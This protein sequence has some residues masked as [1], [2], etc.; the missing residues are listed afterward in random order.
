MPQTR[1][2]R[3]PLIA[4]LG[5]VLWD[6]FPDGEAFGGAPANFAC[7]CQA[8]GADAV[9]VSAVGGDERGR[10]A[11]AFLDEH[12]VDTSYVQVL[13]DAPTGAVVVRLD[14]AGKAGYTFLEN[15]AWDRLSWSAPLAELAGTLDAVCFGTLGQRSGQ[16]RATILRFL[17]ATRA[18]CLRVFDINL[19]QDYHSPALVLS[20]LEA[21]NVLKVNDEELPMLAGWLGLQGPPE[22][23]LAELLDRF[24]LRVA[25]LTCGPRGALMLRPGESSFA[26]PPQ[27]EV[28]STVGA[29]DAFTA[30]VVTGLLANQP[31][32]EINRRANAIAA[33]VCTQQGAVPPLPAG[34]V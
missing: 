21:A 23:Q 6:V 18:E 32:D 20:S 27:V 19:R 25:I 5:E 1:H 12:G 14:E 31:L 11:L 24:S 30:T 28:V 10:R 8:L 15:T 33:Y 29:G 17:K 2:S 3:T 7:H 16:S 4:G 22:R 9:V 34:L 13:P 26:S